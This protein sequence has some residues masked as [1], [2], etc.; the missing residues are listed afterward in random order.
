M[1]KMDELGPALFQETTCFRLPLSWIINSELLTVDTI[2]T[3]PGAFRI[4]LRDI[5]VK[6]GES[7]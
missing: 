2:W 5:F 6:T 3:D 7:Y 4:H 1:M